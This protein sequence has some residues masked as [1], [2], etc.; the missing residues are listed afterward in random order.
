M[1]ADHLD[2]YGDKNAI[3]DSFRE[4]ADKVKDKTK[5]FVPKGLPLK[6]LTVGIN[7]EATFKA[8]NIR[9]EN[10]YYVFDVQT[11]SETI[12]NIHFGLPGR[13]NLM[14]ALM[15]LA[16]AKTY[17]TPTESIAKSLGFI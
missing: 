6:G 15:A 8:F 13:H 9:I 2:I 14:N 11:Q 12:Q 7:E 10:G 3:E 16:M 4:F 17:G 5:I 1:D